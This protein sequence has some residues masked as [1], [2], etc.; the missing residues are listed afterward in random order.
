MEY[1]ILSTIEGIYDGKRKAKRDTYNKVARHSCLLS[2]KLLRQQKK[3]KE[4]RNK[5]D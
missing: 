5:S 3:L 4:L 2:R 1:I